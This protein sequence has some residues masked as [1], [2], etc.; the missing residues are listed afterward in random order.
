[1]RLLRCAPFP[2]TTQSQLHSKQTPLLT[3]IVTAVITPQHVVVD[4][5]DFIFSGANQPL[6][7]MDRTDAGEL[8]RNSPYV[9]EGGVSTLRK[10]LLHN[11]QQV[12]EH[13][14]DKELA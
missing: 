13:T 12:N 11:W 4:P 2:L 10:T 5:N 9:Q 7:P 1:M 8:M 6:A 3:V 14:R